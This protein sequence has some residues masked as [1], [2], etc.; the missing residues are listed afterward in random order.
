MDLI[1]R[2]RF[3]QPADLFEADNIADMLRS[4]DEIVTALYPQRIPGYIS[5]YHGG[6][7]VEVFLLAGV[8]HDIE[9][10]RDLPGMWLFDDS[11]EIFV[12]I[13][14]KLRQLMGKILVHSDADY[15]YWRDTSWIDRPVHLS[16][17]YFHDRPVQSEL[18]YVFNLPRP[19]GVQTLEEN[20][21][22]EQAGFAS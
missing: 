8:N 17:G 4:R 5:R 12:T 11:E 13:P 9:R 22:Q 1:E 7:R 19:V 10:D 16:N 2:G 18:L 3:L 20:L 14:S 15:N 6:I 21:P